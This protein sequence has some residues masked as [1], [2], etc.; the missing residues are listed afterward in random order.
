M[1]NIVDIKHNVNID[2]VIN[3]AELSG[4]FNPLHVDCNYADNNIFG[5][6]V[7][8]GIYQVFL[9]IEIFAQ[10]YNKSFFIKNIKVNFNN[11]LGVNENFF[12]DV[13]AADNDNVAILIRNEEQAVL[14]KMKIFFQEEKAHKKDAYKLINKFDKIPLNPN[15]FSIQDQMEPLVY[16]A[17]SLKKIF[18]NV[19]KFMSELNTSVLLGS[20]RII[21]MKYPGLNSIYCKLDLNFK[22][23]DTDYLKYDVCKQNTSFDIVRINIKNKEISGYLQALIRPIN[24]VQTSLKD[25]TSYV[26]PNMF[27]NQRALIVGASKG[28]GLQC[29]KLL[30]LGNADTLFTYYK[31]DD[32]S[33]ILDEFQQN[34]KKT[35]C[36]LLDINNIT[37]A[38]IL[39]IKKFNPTHMYYFATPKIAGK[40]SILSE[41]KFNN[42]VHYYI[43]ALDK[44]IRMLSETDLKNIFSPSSTFIDELPNGMVEYS[45]AKYASELYFKMLAK[46][47]YNVF[48]PRFPRVRTNQTTSLIDLS[49]S[50][51]EDILIKELSKF[52][53]NKLNE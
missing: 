25:L 22:Q 12:I 20:T 51:P 31:S 50:N 8:H 53:E 33:Q 42:F 35:D 32:F 16:D 27:Q 41:E 46:M 37:E 18:P 40:S 49:E 19:Y 7:V 28:I 30:S 10:S 9:A 47:G 26:E 23:V 34:G 14:T 29:L 17:S 13:I 15:D 39:K 6:Q 11:P 44:L 43:F 38:A 3:F 52:S 45:L 21:G 1:L 36:I 24:H 5:K 2:N 4:D 48:C